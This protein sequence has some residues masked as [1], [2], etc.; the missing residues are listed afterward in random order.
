MRRFF[1]SKLLRAISF[2]LVCAFTASTAKCNKVAM[3][4]WSMGVFG[5]KEQRST[6]HRRLLHIELELDFIIPTLSSLS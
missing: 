3:G 4:A 6:A 5:L 1:L 2:I